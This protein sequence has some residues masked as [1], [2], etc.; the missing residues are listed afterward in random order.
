MNK[1]QLPLK[2]TETTFLFSSPYHVL[3]NCGSGSVLMDWDQYGNF[4]LNKY[5]TF[6][7]FRFDIEKIGLLEFKLI[8]NL[9]KESIEKKMV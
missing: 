7:F 2:K 6:D 4:E 9:L 8:F 1:I 5:K 3:C